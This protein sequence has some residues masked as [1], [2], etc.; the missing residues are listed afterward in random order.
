MTITSAFNDVVA[1][2]AQM[3]SVSNPRLAAI[4][5]QSA[6]ILSQANIS[7]GPNCKDILSNH[8]ADVKLPP[9]QHGKRTWIGTLIAGSKTRFDGTTQASNRPITWLGGDLK[10]SSN[11]NFFSIAI[12]LTST[13]IV[14]CLSLIVFRRYWKTEEVFTSPA[15]SE[16]QF[17]RQHQEGSETL[18]GEGYHM[19]KSN[20]EEG[21]PLGQLRKHIR[22]SQPNAVENPT[23]ESTW[24]S[25]NT[26]QETLV[27]PWGNTKW[28]DSKVSL[29]NNTSDEKCENLIELK[30]KGP[31]KTFFDPKTGKFIHLTPWKSTGEPEIRGLKP[32]R[33][34]NIKRA[35][36]QMTLGATGWAGGINI[37]D[38]LAEELQANS[39]IEEEVTAKL[40]A[41]DGLNLINEP[42]SGK[43]TMV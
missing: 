8:T 34:G 25:H 31:N 26:S 22:N 18:S 2:C 39:Q 28:I 5:A 19:I 37:D 4:H 15:R 23:G 36:A 40:T 35:F 27:G 6:L 10:L 33:K 41:G 38:Q 17:K 13:V 12:L 9:Y 24:Q 11:S 30:T 43:P 42:P 14:G 16:W 29:T 21:H 1:T 3:F 7:L 20:P 32:D